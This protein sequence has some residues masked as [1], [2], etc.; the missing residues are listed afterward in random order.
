MLGCLPVHTE[1]QARD[2]KVVDGSGVRRMKLEGASVCINGLLGF[3][4][5]C[6]GCAETVPEE[7]V[8]RRSK[9]FVIDEPV[10]NNGKRKK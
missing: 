3:P 7:K 4:T 5:V 10:K 6:K 1:V 8:L 2:S 9:R